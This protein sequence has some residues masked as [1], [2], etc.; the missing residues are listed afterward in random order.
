[1]AFTG[2][3]KA[4][5]A[6]LSELGDHNNKDWFEAHRAA[7]DEDLIP[8]MLALCEELT[9]RLRPL[10]PHLSFVPRVGGSLQR[11]NR[12]IRFSR[13]KRPYKTHAA[14]LLWEGAEK[15]NSPAVYV[16]ISPA[17]VIFGG[18]LYEF[19]E[20]QLDRYRKL[21]AQERS[22][23]RLGEALAIAKQAG[24]DVDGA[25]LARVPRG[26][27]PD[28]PRAELLKHKGLYVGRAQKPGAWLYTAEVLDRAEAA[29]TAYAPLH[30]WLRDEVCK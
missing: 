23:E 6:F 12:D 8:A 24:M 27:S 4:S 16:Q 10:M 25:K 17:E 28:H 1:M 2:F 22:G 21:C 14:A 5:L 18:G 13:D 7:W 15:Q 11:L 9:C 30:A 3:S 19:E 26:V 29:A 20:G